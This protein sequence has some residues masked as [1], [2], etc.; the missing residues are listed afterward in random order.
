MEPGSL[1]R[2]QLRLRK[3]DV[4]HAAVGNT[5]VRALGTHLDLRRV[6]RGGPSS[7][8]GPDYSVFDVIQSIAAIKTPDTMKVR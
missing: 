7:T 8:Y 3:R 1:C 2:S 4:D 6:A 5:V